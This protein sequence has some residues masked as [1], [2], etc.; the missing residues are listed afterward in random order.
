MG[1]YLHTNPQEVPRWSWR[2]VVDVVEAHALLCASDAINASPGQPPPQRNPLTTERHV[3]AMA[4]EGLFCGD[5][6]VGMFTL[7]RDPPRAMDSDEFGAADQAVYMQRLAVHPDWVERDALLGVRCVK[8]ALEIARE[9]G[10]S[11]LRAEANPR[12]VKVMQ[13]LRSFGFVQ[14]GPVRG[15]MGGVQHVNM[16]CA[17][18]MHFQDVLR[19]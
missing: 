19:H 15:E 18:H 5:S 11:V 6:L 1:G 2:S 4:V 12:L 7:T 16:Q 10:A 13:L 9:R 3:L 17:V 8:R 14:V